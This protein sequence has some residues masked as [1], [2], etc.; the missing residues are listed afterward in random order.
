MKAPQVA[1]LWK[2]S[3]YDSPRP[4]R[5]PALLTFSGGSLPC[6]KDA[7]G[8]PTKPGDYSFVWRAGEI[9]S[10]GPAL[11]ER[12]EG[13]R[14]GARQIGTARPCRSGLLPSRTSRGMPS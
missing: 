3:G 12:R 4:A 8:Q 14:R 7:H 1:Q 13:D 9:F 11:P 6:K 10:G 5:L 2:I